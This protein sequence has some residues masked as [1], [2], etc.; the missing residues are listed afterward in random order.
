MHKS[1]RQIRV[2]LMSLVV[3]TVLAG[4]PSTSAIHAGEFMSVDESIELAYQNNPTLKARV[5][6]V[7]QARGKVVTARAPFLPQVDAKAGFEHYLRTPGVNTVSP[8]HPDTHI[9]NERNLPQASV[10]L[11]QTIYDFGKTTYS[12]RQAKLGENI[13]ESNVELYKQDLALDVVRVYFGVLLAE[14]GL[15][16]A[17][18]YL[19]SLNEHYRIALNLYNQNVVSKNDLLTADVA[20]SQAGL[21]VNQSEHTLRL[22]KLNFEKVV[23]VAPIHLKRKI[24][25]YTPMP[26]TIA[27]AV[28]EAAENRVE[29]AINDLKQLRAD[30]QR[31]G[32]ISEYLPRLYASAKAQFQD[33]EILIHKDQYVFGVGLQW[34]IFDGLAGKGRYDSAKAKKKR[35]QHQKKALMDKIQ[36]QVTRS[37]L[38]L[39]QAKKAI[40]VEKKNKAQA[41]ENLRLQGNMYEQGASSAYDFLNAE[42]IWVNSQYS[43]YQALYNYNV[44]KANAYRSI[45]LPIK[46]VW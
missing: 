42:A 39:E 28:D 18:A 40:V 6:G 35:L 23:G 21:R 41:T 38:D 27:K 9:L 12:Y 20:R 25:A 2:T 8:G 16:V 22:A 26:K 11:D 36:V 37:L 45:G 31:K 19:K 34:P 33:T 7:D 43:Y 10:E 1:T 32:A 24:L 3:M 29:L 14:K 4:V 15:D 30:A 46:G 13:S 17:K 5:S 44:A